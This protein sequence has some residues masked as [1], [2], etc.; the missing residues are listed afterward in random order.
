M[1][2]VFLSLFDE[3]HEIDFIDDACGDFALLAFEFDLS[4]SVEKGVQATM[5]VDILKQP[6]PLP[7]TLGEFLL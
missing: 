7:D 1:M 3:L 2:V 6:L 4:V 5:A